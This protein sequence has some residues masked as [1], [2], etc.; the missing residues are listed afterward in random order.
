MRERSRFPNLAAAT[1]SLLLVLPLFV[2]GAIGGTRLYEGQATYGAAAFSPLPRLFSSRRHL[3]TRRP[4]TSSRPEAAPMGTVV[5]PRKGKEL[6]AIHS[7]PSSAGRSS[8]STPSHDY[9][10]GGADGSSSAAAWVDGKGRLAA[11]P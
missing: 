9:A 2:T 7:P 5:D 6:A 8:S 3:P 4:S 11:V 10:G 1:P